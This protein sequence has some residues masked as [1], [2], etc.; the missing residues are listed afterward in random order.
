MSRYNALLA[1][2]ADEDFQRFGHGGLPFDLAP[3]SE[4]G[5]VPIVTPPFYALPCFPLARKSMGGVAVDLEGRVLDTSGR[6][7]PGLRAV[8]ELTGFGGVNG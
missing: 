4:Q 7:I 6:P 5:A 8:G 1:E 2:G 3:G